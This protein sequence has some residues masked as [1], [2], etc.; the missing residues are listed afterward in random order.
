MIS[1]EPTPL[2]IIDEELERLI[3]TEKTASAGQNEG[4]GILS[5]AEEATSAAVDPIEATEAIARRQRRNAE[6][7]CLKGYSMYVFRSGKKVPQ[8][9]CHKT[10]AHDKCGGATFIKYGSRACEPSN[11][12][13]VRDDAPYEHVKV[14]IAKNCSCKV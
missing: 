11:V 6:P 12:V 3:L 4:P 2:D 1:P 13:M 5:V 9:E 7:S 8:A 14:A 10:A